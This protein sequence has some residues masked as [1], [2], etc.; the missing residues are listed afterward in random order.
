ASGKLGVIAPGAVAN[1]TVTRGPLFNEASKVR[2]VWVDGARYEV[3]KDETSPKGDWNI[4]WGHG[5]HALSVKT[6]ADTS[7]KL[8]VGSDTLK[9]RDVRLDGARLLFTLQRGADEPENFDL[10][11]KNDALTGKLSVASGG[12]HAVTGA[13]KPKDDAKPK[14]P[15]PPVPVPV[16]SG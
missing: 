15:E 9:A 10:L 2:E 4:D 3:T 1:L 13:P 11:A 16:V 12:S 14:K 7:V 5:P 6:D 8:V